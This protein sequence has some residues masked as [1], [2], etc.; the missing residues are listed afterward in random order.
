MKKLLLVGLA[1]FLFL[2]GIALLLTLFL[3]STS[4]ENLSLS[5]SGK[6]AVI[7]IKG[8]IGSTDALRD[9]VSAEHV[10]EDLEEAETDPSIKGIFLDID[11]PGGSV[12]PTKQIVYKIREIEKPI[13]AYVGET[14]ASGAYYIA[15]ASDYIVADE[16]SLTGSIG[17]ISLVPNLEGLLEKI[18]AKMQVF[19]EG[20][21]KAFASPFTEMTEEQRAIMQGLLS[22]IYNKFKSDVLSF[23]KGKI[24]AKLFNELADGRVLSGRQALDAGLIDATGTRKEA[25]KKAA[26]LAGIEGEP[27][28]VKYGK[29]ELSLVDFFMEAGNAFGGAFRQSLFADAK[30]SIR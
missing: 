24:R 23:R 14:G 4:G 19:K 18:G 2:V 17:V 27:E 8:E 22:D 3:A 11:S 13:V 26:E 28:L 25:L 7:P 12:V 20:E 10:V 16:D 29:K 1:A 5:L 6:L 30:V 15:A 9:A 21:N